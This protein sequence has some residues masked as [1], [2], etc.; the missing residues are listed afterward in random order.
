MLH[1]DLANMANLVQSRLSVLGGVGGAGSWK[2]EARAIL[3]IQS[4]SELVDKIERENASA[5]RQLDYAFE[6]D[7][8]QTIE[9]HHDDLKPLLETISEKQPHLKLFRT[10]GQTFWE[11][12]GERNDFED[13]EILRL[14]APDGYAMDWEWDFQTN[15]DG[16]RI[17]VCHVKFVKQDDTEKQGNSFRMGRHVEEC[18]DVL[19]D[20]DI[21]YLWGWAASSNQ[22]KVRETRNGENWR[23]ELCQITDADGELSPVM[24]RLLATYLRQGW[25]MMNEQKEGEELIAYM[26][27]NGIDYMVK[28]WGNEILEEFK[29]AKNYEAINSRYKIR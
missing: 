26:S 25:I 3:E 22:F 29:Y 6:E 28:K 21:V 17:R 24:I 23:G 27:P 19:F 12:D 8:L 4:T 18:V 5:Y 13:C 7:D 14:A 16:K 1:Q 11:H 10:V 20:H 2:D 9:K 15:N